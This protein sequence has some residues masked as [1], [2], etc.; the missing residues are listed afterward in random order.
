MTEIRDVLTTKG[1]NVEI[2]VNVILINYMSIIVREAQC[3][4]R[5]FIKLNF[6]AIIS[7]LTGFM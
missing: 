5:L 3:P 7:D 6:D 4:K 1:F 2:E